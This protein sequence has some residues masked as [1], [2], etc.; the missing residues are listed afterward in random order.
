VL[1]QLLSADLANTLPDDKDVVNEFSPIPD[2]TRTPSGLAMCDSVM[3]KRAKEHKVF[4]YLIAM[5]CVYAVYDITTATAFQFLSTH[6]AYSAATLEDV[7]GKLLPVVA[8]ALFPF[9]P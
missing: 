5:V 7:A 3:A 8:V 2:S 9:T 6:L 1:L 4:V